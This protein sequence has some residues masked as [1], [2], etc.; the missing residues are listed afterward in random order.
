MQ[1]GANAPYCIKGG[2]QELRYYELNLEQRIDY[3]CKLFI[4]NYH[5]D[6]TL[7]PVALSKH[8]SDVALL[9][10]TN[11]TI[12]VSYI[13]KYIEYED[14]LKFI[15]HNTEKLVGYL[16]NSKNQNKVQFEFDIKMFHVKHLQGGSL[17]EK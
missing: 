2:K 6:A 12:I 3:L 15:V 11:N 1:W 5:S 8:N 16:S 17:C 14:R 10:Y 7:E 13:N 9:N 4:D